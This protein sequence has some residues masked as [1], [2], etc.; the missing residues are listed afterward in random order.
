[1]ANASTNQS[2]YGFGGRGGCV[3]PS[4]NPTENWPDNTRRAAATVEQK[5]PNFYQLPAGKNIVVRSRSSKSIEAFTHCVYCK[6]AIRNGEEFSPMTT[7]FKYKFQKDVTI[8]GLIHEDCIPMHED[9]QKGAIMSN[10]NIKN[11]I[12]TSSQQDIQ[13]LADKIILYGDMRLNIR[14]LQPYLKDVS[15]PSYVKT[16]SQRGTIP[17]QPLVLDRHTI[18]S[19]LSV[20]Y[21]GEIN[22]NTRC[23]NRTNGSNQLYDLNLCNG[24]LLNVK[25]TKPNNNQDVCDGVEATVW[26]ISQDSDS[27]KSNKLTIIVLLTAIQSKCTALETNVKTRNMDLSWNDMAQVHKD[28]VE[29][30][31]PYVAQLKKSAETP[32]KA[33]D[34]EY[35]PQCSRLN[36]YAHPLSLDTSSGDCTNV[37]INTQMAKAQNS[38]KCVLPACVADDASDNP[39]IIIHGWCEWLLPLFYKNSKELAQYIQSANQNNTTHTVQMSKPYKV[40]YK[41][42][43]ATHARTTQC[44][45]LCNNQ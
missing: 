1:M 29:I 2:Q 12:G 35:I 10:I 14:T 30:C 33:N 37:L 40:A 21:T 31:E 8:T 44:S 15:R 41:K 18:E 43:G 7:T 9:Q 11:N 20:V 45:H 17:V 38:F 6:N 4:P 16:F 42:M 3:I 22:V 23:G 24:I 13:Y 26:I 32:I 39:P 34:L 5:H 25:L 27:H 36:I 19:A 28:F